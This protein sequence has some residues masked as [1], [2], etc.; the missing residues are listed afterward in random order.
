MQ[1]KNGKQANLRKTEGRKPH[2]QHNTETYSGSP[3]KQKRNEKK[4]GK[5]LKMKENGLEWEGNRH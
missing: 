5:Y 2:W 1:G 3:A 4:E